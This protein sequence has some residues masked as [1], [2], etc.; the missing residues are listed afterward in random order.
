MRAVVY[1]GAAPR[2]R[3]AA[4][5]ALAETVTGHEAPLR[6]AWHRASATTGTDESVAQEL[7]KAGTGM[8]M[9][10]GFAA[11]ASA[12]ERA[13]ALSEDDENRARRLLAAGNAAYL[14]G[15]LDRARAAA[16]TAIEHTSDPLLQADCARLRGSVEYYARNILAPIASWWRRP[17]GSRDTTLCGRRNC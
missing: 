12:L 8:A 16:L 7:E 15:M 5:R 4:H 14:A 10:T 17:S 6:R 9:R 13:A 3:R 11:A 2:D 1:R